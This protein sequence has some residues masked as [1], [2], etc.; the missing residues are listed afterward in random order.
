MKRPRVSIALL[1]VVVALVAV[2]VAALRNPSETW[3]SAVFTLAVVVLCLAVFLAFATGGR[4]RL[5]WMSFAI[6]GWAYLIFTFGPSSGSQMVNPPPL[7]FSTWVSSG[8]GYL[9]TRL[10][11]FPASPTQPRWKTI[12]LDSNSF[13]KVTTRQYI[14]KVR[15]LATPNFAPFRQIGHSIA[16]LL[17]SII[18]SVLVAAFVKHDATHAGE[19]VS[20]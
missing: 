3:A 15:T 1:M 7:I 10:P 18:A 11:T 8:L 17:I 9:E 16:T 6:S 19:R 5:A 14:S 12:T 2:A 20:P 13:N 4:K